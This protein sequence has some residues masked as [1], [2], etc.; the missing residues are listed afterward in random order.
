MPAVPSDVLLSDR[1]APRAGSPGPGAVAVA[2]ARQLRRQGCCNAQLP[3]S[4]LNALCA[5]NGKNRALLA[6]EQTQRRAALAL[7]GRAVMAH[8]GC[9][10]GA[11][12]GQA[13]RHLAEAVARDPSLN[14]PESLRDL[15]DAWSRD[16]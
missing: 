8:L 5:L 16:T 14:R 6:R 12:V 13:L 2:R 4:R 7:D 3:G 15:L 1:V 10:P 9:G 11:R